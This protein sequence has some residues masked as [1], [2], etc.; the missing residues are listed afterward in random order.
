MNAN[1]RK[2]YQAQRRHQAQIAAD[3]GGVLTTYKSGRTER[4]YAS[5]AYGF[6]AAAALAA[7]RYLVARR[8][9]RAA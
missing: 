3:G 9:E 4:S 7:A 8:A 2:T 1:I 5:A 6:H